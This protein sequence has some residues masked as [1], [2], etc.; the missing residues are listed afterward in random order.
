MLRI[1][2]ALA[3]TAVLSGCGDDAAQTPR[4]EADPPVPTAAITNADARL[5]VTTHRGTDSLSG[6][7]LKG[8]CSAGAVRVE[9]GH[10]APYE[11]L[12][13]VGDSRI[14]RITPP[15]RAALT[16]QCATGRFVIRRR[17]LSVRLGRG[18]LRVTASGGEAVD[19][20]IKTFGI[21]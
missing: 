21:E 10:A 8:T 12:R 15:E 7:R 16:A 5:S 19:I 20:R 1:S 13:K 4:S 18:P 14:D 6:L 3:L 17:Q 11:P 9:V 2:T